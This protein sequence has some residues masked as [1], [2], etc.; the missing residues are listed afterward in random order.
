M[1]ILV[2]AL[3]T[4]GGLGR[5][6]YAPGSLG[7]VPAIALAWVLQDAHWSTWF[8]LCWSL[9]V[10][11]TW[12]ADLYVHTLVDS[13][14]EDPSTGHLDPQEVVLDEFLGCFIAL[15]FVPFSWPWVLAAYV[16]FRFFDITKPGPIG[17]AERQLSGGLGIMTDDVLA[18]LLA[19]LL[20][21]GARESYLAF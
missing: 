3:V 11:G 10:V 18:G 9:W 14:D 8:V 1:A 21:L 15:A 19:G 4:V 12:L 2:Q 20:L 17:K 6:P 13:E 5:S 7:A 16:L